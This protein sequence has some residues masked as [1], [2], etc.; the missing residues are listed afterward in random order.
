M[1]LPHLPEHGHG[2]GAHVPKPT[3]TAERSP[4]RRTIL[5]VDDNVDAANSVAELLNLLGNDAKV[6]HDGT[7]ALD[8]I[9]ETVPDIVLLDISLPDIDGFEVARRIRAQHQNAGITLIALTG[10]GQDSDKDQ[11]IEA[12]FDGYWVKPVSLEQLRDI[13][14]KK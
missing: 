12:G 14:Q 9:E 5:I 7:T 1:C 8:A 10:W 6:V 2:A 4:A 11:S 13:S 3:S